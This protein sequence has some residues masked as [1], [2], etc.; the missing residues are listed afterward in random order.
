MRLFS[1]HG[2]LITYM[3]TPVGAGPCGLVG[4]TSKWE[5]KKKLK[6]KKFVV[7]VVTI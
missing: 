7:N 5:P 6:T 1:Q 2:L 4:G 3:R